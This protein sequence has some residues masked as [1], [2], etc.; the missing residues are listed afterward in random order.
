MV[1]VALMGSYNMRQ[2][3]S[4][5]P[6]TCAKQVRSIICPSVKNRSPVWP[7]LACGQFSRTTF[8]DR[9]VVL[10]VTKTLKCH[11]KYN[12]V[13]KKRIFQNSF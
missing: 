5:K 1:M 2:N 11:W 12:K 10:N 4:R 9:A 7:V 13:E 6:P 3:F 8:Q